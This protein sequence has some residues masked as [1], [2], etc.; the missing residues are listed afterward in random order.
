[1]TQTMRQRIAD[2]AA[3]DD[4]FSGLVLSGAEVQQLHGEIVVLESLVRAVDAN[5][6]TLNDINGRNWFDVRDEVTK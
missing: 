1:M 5:A 6:F 4:L 2:A 3:D